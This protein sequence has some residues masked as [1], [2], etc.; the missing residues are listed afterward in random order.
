MVGVNNIEF[1][2]KP[3]RFDASLAQN[4]L[5]YLSEEAQH[6][7]ST[8]IRKILLSQIFCNLVSLRTD[9]IA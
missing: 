8:K 3:K 1:D 4:K 2:A 5:G 6:Q 9:W 7:L